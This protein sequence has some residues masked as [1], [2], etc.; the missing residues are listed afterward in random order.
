[1]VK[2]M[3]SKA[4]SIFSAWNGQPSGAVCW[5]LSPKQMDTGNLALGSS[6]LETRKKEERN[7]SKPHC[8]GSVVSY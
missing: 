2:V 4:C 3:E 6:G 1:M 8:P 7:L 5:G